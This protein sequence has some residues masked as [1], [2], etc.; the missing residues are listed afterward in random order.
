MQLISFL[1]S[2]DIR[3]AAFGVRLGGGGVW[4][5]EWVPRKTIIA[6]N[7]VS[8]TNLSSCKNAIKLAA[9]C[10][11]ASRDDDDHSKEERSGFGS[12]P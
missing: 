6:Q 5:W 3:C 4:K 1:C 10:M 2:N 9:K 11:P 12:W 7:G 8:G